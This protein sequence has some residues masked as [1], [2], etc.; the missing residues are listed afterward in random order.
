MGTSSVT[1]ASAGA[2]DGAW[3]KTNNKATRCK[4]HTR[5]VGGLDSTGIS[6]ERHV[7]QRFTRF[8][9]TLCT[10]TWRRNTTAFSVYSTTTI[11]CRDGQV[12]KCVRLRNVPAVTIAIPLHYEIYMRRGC[13]DRDV[14]P[15]FWRRA[16]TC[17]IYRDA[18]VGLG[19]SWCWHS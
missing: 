6:E 11:R 18:V 17:A 19:G 12:V 4:E 8:N 13:G 7:C 3:S 16:W 14:K 1:G 2:V 9:V 10:R 15:V 5:N